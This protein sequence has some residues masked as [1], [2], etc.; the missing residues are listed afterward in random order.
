MTQRSESEEQDQACSPVPALL[1]VSKGTDGGG[2]PTKS[3]SAG[4]AC[5][6]SEIRWAVSPGTHV[7]AGSGG[8]TRVR[9]AVSVSQG[10]AP[11]PNM[12]ELGARAAR[13][14]LEEQHQRGSRTT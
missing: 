14:E 11:Q 2:A 6:I 10:A 13:R 9:T 8:T 12:A 1:P 4:D 7:G 3:P 5:G